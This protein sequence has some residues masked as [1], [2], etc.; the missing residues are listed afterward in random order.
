MPLPSSP[1]DSSVSSTSDSSPIPTLLSANMRERSYLPPPLPPYPSTPVNRRPSGVSQH[2]TPDAPFRTH[3]LKPFH[4]TRIPK[5]RVFFKRQAPTPSFFEDRDRSHSASQGSRLHPE[6]PQSL[7]SAY[8]L[9]ALL[10]EP[11][12]ISDFS[13][14]ARAQRGAAWT[15]VGNSMLEIAHGNE[16]HNMSSLSEENR[17]F[18]TQDD[19]LVPEWFNTYQPAN[20]NS[21]AE[22][23]EEDMETNS[24]NEIEELQ[25]AGNPFENLRSSSLLARLVVRSDRPP[26]RGSIISVRPPTI[27][28]R[29]GIRGRGSRGRDAWPERAV[30]MESRAQEDV[31]QSD[32]IPVTGQAAYR[33]RARRQ[34]AWLRLFGRTI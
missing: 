28:E 12:C 34:R 31:Q 15:S 19:E 3:F 26:L 30:A 20:S 5:A 8:P 2:S 25:H 13:E 24:S 22:A 4:S 10:P 27:R 33:S 9:R 18:M 1:R 7:T 17:S 11:R 21:I 16:D 6:R 23:S 32:M 29:F 14:V